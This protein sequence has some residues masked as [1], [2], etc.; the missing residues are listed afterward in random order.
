[1]ALI[2]SIA[3]PSIT[4]PFAGY[5]LKADAQKMVQVLRLA[6]Q[7]TITSGRS[8]QVMFYPNGSKYKSYDSSGTA[9]THML[10]TGNKILGT[11][12]FTQRFGILPVCAFSPTGAPSSGGT[13]ILANSVN[14]KLYIIVNPAA[15]RIRVSDQPPAS[16]E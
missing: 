4:R 8:N 15:G 6:R 9:T 1:M 16:W 10:N 5:K 14:Q 2:A 11:P 3:A 13:V 7:C 12:T